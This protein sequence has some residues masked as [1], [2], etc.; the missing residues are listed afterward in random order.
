VLEGLAGGVGAS[1]AALVLAGLLDGHVPDLLVLALRVLVPLVA[2]GGTVALGLLRYRR[3]RY[4]LRD[5]EID[6]LHG[7]LVVTR[8]LIPIVRVQHVDT[9]RTWLADQ[10]G[11]QAVVVHTAANSHEI[12]ALTPTEAAA[13]RDRI[14]L[15]ARQPDEL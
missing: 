9:R 13:I 5:E 7:A 10:I 14:A 12:P 2:L 1:I 15:L 4:E 8:T 3:W 11:V 6:L